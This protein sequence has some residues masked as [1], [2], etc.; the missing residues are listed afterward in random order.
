MGMGIK[1]GCLYATLIANHFLTLKG[2]SEKVGRV[3]EKIRMMSY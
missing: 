3:I 1:S 2:F